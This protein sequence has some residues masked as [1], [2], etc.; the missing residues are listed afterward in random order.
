MLKE[1]ISWRLLINTKKENTTN[2]VI[3]EENNLIV[4]EVSGYPAFYTQMIFNKRDAS[5]KIKTVLNNTVGESLISKCE[6][7]VNF[8]KES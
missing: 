5:I 7:V 1:I 8:K 4:S 2:K 6:N 3:I